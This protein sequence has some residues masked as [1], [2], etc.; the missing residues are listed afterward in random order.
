MSK[1]IGLS[2][3]N[4][5]ITLVALVVTIVIL[6]ILAGISISMLMEN[7]G[8][9]A[10][11]QEASRKTEQ[12]QKEEEA[13][14]ADLESYINNEGKSIYNETDG[15]NR[16]ELTEG[17]IPVKYDTTKGKWVITNI[18]D[19][20]WYNY[21]TGKQWANVMLSDGK[22][23]V[24]N[25][26]EYKTDGTTVVE[27][28]DLGSMFVW[29]PR[30]SYKITSGYHSSEAGTIDVKFLVGRSNQTADNTTIVEY[31]ATTTNN[32]TQ[33]PDGYVVHP[34]FTSNVNNGGWDKEISGIWVS[35]FEAGY[36]MADTIDSTTKT[37]SNLYYPVFKGQRYSYNNTTIGNCYTVSQQMRSEGNPYGI[38][39]SSN[40]HMIKNSEWGAVA[41]LSISTHG[42]NSEIYPNNVSFENSKTNINGSSVY[43]ITGYS[44]IGVNNETLNATGLAIGETIGTSTVWYN[45][46]N[47]INSSTTGNI[48]GIYDMSG[49]AADYVSTTIPTGNSS[50]NSYGSSFAL[51]TESTKYVTVY[52][53]GN[54]TQTE[55]DISRSY[56]AFGSMYG[57]AVWETSST[58]GANL[59][60]SGD[61]SDE[62]SSSYEPFFLRGG[63]WNYGSKAGSFAFVDNSG[64]ASNGCTYR[65]VLVVE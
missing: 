15:V 24:S 58:I 46:T 12:S 65:A 18:D 53:I 60:W 52:P 45:T 19:I 3:T 49:G 21:K 29:I 23:K 6:L 2:N 57:D 7:N 37:S 27:I 54:S 33:F 39:S 16:P 4:R 42:K 61:R 8:I 55:N 63:A 25:S 47:G 36:P 11:A 34:A 50:L 48:Y 31:N 14:L 10:K 32:Y 28:S 5:G 13:A 9:I 56:P 38:T 40:S 44:A 62:D 17:M 43:G 26:S 59:S 64:Y 20:N 51:I 1:K 35:K 41:Y 22:Y 30:Y